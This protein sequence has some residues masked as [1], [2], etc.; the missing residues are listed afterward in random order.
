[1]IIVHGIVTI[2]A[3]AVTRSHSRPATLASDWL[4]V[5]SDWRSGNRYLTMD[6]ESAFWPH[7]VL[8]WH[9]RTGFWPVD[10]IHAPS[11]APYQPDQNR[12][13]PPRSGNQFRHHRRL[14]HRLA[15]IRIRTT[16]LSAEDE[17]FPDWVDSFLR[18]PTSI[19]MTIQHTTNHTINVSPPSR[20]AVIV[21]MSPEPVVPLFA[22]IY[23]QGHTVASADDILEGIEEGVPGT[24][25][26]V[27]IARRG[28]LHGR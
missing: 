20:M 26:S 18:V 2:W 24:M 25:V 23:R 17:E 10:A 8:A 21:P 1:M 3:W 19:R 12:L 5:S 4:A 16:S 11:R 13:H 22:G 9:S 6:A 28:H 15:G 14:H 27:M 7:S